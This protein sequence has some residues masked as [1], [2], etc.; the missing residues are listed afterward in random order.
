MR[1]L[2]HYTAR[3]SKVNKC[4]G[5]WRG[6]SPAPLPV[7][8][9]QSMHATVM[10]CAARLGCRETIY[11]VG[12]R[13]VRGM[14]STV[15]WPTQPGQNTR[16]SSHARFRDSGR[17]WIHG[18]TARKGRGASP[19]PVTSHSPASSLA[20]GMPCARSESRGWEKRAGAQTRRRAQMEVEKRD[21][22]GSADASRVSRTP[23]YLRSG[24][25]VA[26]AAAP[27]ASAAAPHVYGAYSA[28][29]Q[30]RRGQKS[31]GAGRGRGGRT[32]GEG[33][34]RK[35]RR[36]VPPRPGFDQLGNR[37]YGA[38]PVYASDADIQ[39]VLDDQTDTGYRHTDE[40]DPPADVPGRVW[41]WER[42]HWQL[43]L[44]ERQGKEDTVA[45]VDII[46]PSGVDRTKWTYRN[47]LYEVIGQGN[48]IWTFGMD[49]VLIYPG[50]DKQKLKKIFT[51]WMDSDVYN[52]ARTDYEK[53]YQV[54]QREE[55]YEIVSILNHVLIGDPD[56]P[57]NE[58]KVE[59]IVRWLGDTSDPGDA[60]LARNKADPWIR[61]WEVDDPNAA[62]GL[63]MFW[64]VPHEE[65]EETAPARLYKYWRQHEMDH[66]DN[67]WPL[68]ANEVL[69][70]DEDELFEDGNLASGI[71]DFKEAMAIAS[72]R[73]LFHC[74]VCRSSRGASSLTACTACERAFCISSIGNEGCAKITMAELAKQGGTRCVQCFRADEAVRVP[75]YRYSGKLVDWAQSPVYADPV[76]AVMVH[77]REPDRHSMSELSAHIVK[78]HLGEYYISSQLY[79]LVEWIDVEVSETGVRWMKKG[80]DIYSSISPIDGLQRATKELARNMKKK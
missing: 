61:P 54:H 79:P 47:V 55:Q 65:L 56:L 21:A 57:K 48:E 28:S 78:A 37:I 60:Y 5:E 26:S 73:R 76:L 68:V 77:W 80:E 4:F 72:H 58:W 15:R 43:F 13:E 2:Q 75:P 25:Q 36:V 62:T 69:E 71:T 3:K 31:T 66:N 33:G 34:P 23:K 53:H 7:H 19:A 27:V 1:G 20:T 41:R 29:A 30:G 24:F 16:R 46:P 40:D 59:Y 45:L 17:H 50:W 67:E 6:A 35:R 11:S 22:F 42:N 10:P 39:R 64:R 8:T 32:Q 49:E 44:T 70:W 74:S 38:Q 14:P 9:T 63:H 51:A 52:A 12:L 18:K